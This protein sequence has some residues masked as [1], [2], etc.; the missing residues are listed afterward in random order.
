MASSQPAFTIAQRFFTTAAAHPDYPALRHGET[1]L[2]YRD[3]ADAVRRAAA[4]A[5]S[6]AA[7]APATEPIAILGRLDVWTPL[8]LLAVF[9][10]GRAACVLDSSLPAQRLQE[11]LEDLAPTAVLS[12]V[13]HD[14]ALVPAAASFCCLTPE[15]L[16]SGPLP[17]VVGREVLDSAAL[18]QYSSGTTGKP[19]GIVRSQRALI[20]HTQIHYR[21][22]APQAA[23]VIASLYHPAYGAAT[24]DIFVALWYGAQVVL[25]NPTGRTPSQLAA[26]LIQAELTH[27]HLHSSLLRPLSDALP[28]G[29]SFPRLRSL[30]PSDRTEGADLRRFTAHLPADCVVHHTLSSIETGPMARFQQRADAAWPDGPLPVGAPIADVTLRLLDEAGNDVTPGAIGRIQVSGPGVALGYWRDPERT[31]QVFRATEDPTIGVFESADLARLLPSGELQLHGRADRRVKIRGHSVALDAV[32]QAL[33]TLPDVA[34]AAAAAFPDQHGN[35]QLF[36]YVSPSAGRHCDPL[37]LTA[38]LRRRRE[39]AL[40]PQR[41]LVLEQLPRRPN[42][43][44]DY[45]ALPL[46][47]RTRPPSAA[48]YAA[49]DSPLTAQI[50][51]VWAAVLELE[52]IGIDDDFVALGGDSIRALQLLHRL[53]QLHGGELPADMLLNGSTVRRQAALLQQAAQPTPDAVDEPRHTGWSSTATALRVAVNRIIF[54]L[55]HA[56][57]RLLL[58]TGFI[59]RQYAPQRRL[60]QQLS[61]A[62]GCRLPEPELWRRSVL[63]NLLLNRPFWYGPQQKLQLVWRDRYD[64]L[65]ADGAALRIVGL[66]H[67]E[68]AR[69]TGT[70]AILVSRHDVARALYKYRLAEHLGLPPIRSVSAARANSDARRT[71]RSAAASRGSTAF[72]ALAALRRGGIILFASDNPQQSDAS[73]HLRFHTG[74]RAVPPGFAEVALLSGAPVLPV[75]HR[76]DRDGRVSLVIGAPFNRPDPDLPHEAQLTVLLQQY[77]DWLAARIAEDPASLQWRHLP[78]ELDYAPEV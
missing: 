72:N 13:P 18:I 35:L 58:R 43:K 74:T 45:Q 71:G 8:L 50:A 77:A 70:G 21:A 42:G 78:R 59:D 14:A 4:A 57:V 39:A 2:T 12:T 16:C 26:E 6:A 25:I 75:H 38:E 22:T 34:D 62:Y 76:C 51:A 73:H 15:A 65:V 64:R 55:L 41:I 30:R 31:A 52:P 7:A 36:A 33:L 23:D 10:S 56:V 61:A 40:L 11:L 44:I 68:I 37:K 28:D 47:G 24:S 17:A 49:A 1:L 67:L 48:P 53:E 9:S 69:H 29:I 20:N 3:A 46:P 54:A 5:E 63:A 60:L 66:E 19:K 32:E 27:L